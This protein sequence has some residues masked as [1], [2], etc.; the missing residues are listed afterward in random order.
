MAN[1]TVLALPMTIIP[2]SISR[3]ASVAVAGEIR[4]SQC[5][6]PPVVMRPSM[7]MMSLSAIG[8]PCQGPMAWPARIA[9]CA[10]SAQARA[11]SR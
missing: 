1:S 10:A 5:L 9:L 7:S 2:A 3:R 11:S 6:L 4:F 8:T